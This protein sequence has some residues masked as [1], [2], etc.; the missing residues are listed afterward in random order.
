MRITF[1][2]PKFEKFL[3][4]LPELDQGL[5][6]YFLGDFTTPPSLG[7]PLLAALTPP[8]IEI[9]LIDDNSGQPIDYDA[10]TDLVAINGFTPQAKR[11]LEIA[12]RYRAHGRKVVMG[13]LFPSFM[14]DEC[15]RHADAVNV[16]EG[17]PTWRQIIEDARAGSLKPQYDGGCG[18][19]LNT[20]PAARREIFYRHDFY[21]WDEDLV[22]LTRGCSYACAMCALPAQMGGRIRF[23]PIERV[24][25]E[26]RGLRHENVYLAD[27]TL[28]F[29]HRKM[30][31]YARGRSELDHPMTDLALMWN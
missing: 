25:E 10:P 1:V 7:I 31:E 17:E 5:V 8:D 19:D 29:P 21:D 18:T 4:S 9:E 6:N 22:Q 28:F 26:I 11:A 3:A 27:D 12:D 23:R 2:Y 13:G 24:V 14:A 15:L 30:N 20:L 16:G